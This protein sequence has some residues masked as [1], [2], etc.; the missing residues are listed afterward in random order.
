MIY[1]SFLGDQFSFCLYT[2]DPVW[3]SRVG[4]AVCRL[5][6]RLSIQGFGGNH[7]ADAG[8]V[9]C[10]CV[11][12]QGAR[13]TWW[14]APCSLRRGGVESGVGGGGVRGVVGGVEWGCV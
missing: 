6:K 1:F 11:C 7:A 3:V 9:V 8:G 12:A 10:V 14:R 5:L 13:C 4:T 2:Q